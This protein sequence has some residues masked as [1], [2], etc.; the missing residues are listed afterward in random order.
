[1]W[2]RPS[3]CSCSRTSSNRVSLTHLSVFPC[4]PAAPYLHYKLPQVIL[5]GVPVDI[6][7][8]RLLGIASLAGKYL[9]ERKLESIIQHPRN[10][11]LKHRRRLLKTRIGVYFDEPRSELC[12]ND[13]IVPEDLEAKLLVV[14]KFASYRLQ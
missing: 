7:N 8:L 4:S 9:V 2:S 13:K 3:H 11:L 1:M 14:F 10:I 5:T 12:I 6:K